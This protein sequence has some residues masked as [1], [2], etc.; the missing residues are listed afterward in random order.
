MLSFYFA[1]IGR[2]SLSFCLQQ[3]FVGEDQYF[4][5]PLTKGRIWKVSKIDLSTLTVG[6]RVILL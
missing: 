1:V 3:F 5:L 2:N 4:K 6:F